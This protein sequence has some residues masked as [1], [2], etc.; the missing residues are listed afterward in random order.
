MF[1]FQGEIVLSESKMLA[2]ILVEH[3]TEKGLKDVME[4]QKK[5][6][7]FFCK[8]CSEKTNHEFFFA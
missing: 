1:Y 7:H 8:L 3:S 6:N 2:G 4:G 5:L